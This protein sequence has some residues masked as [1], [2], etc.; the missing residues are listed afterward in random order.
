MTTQFKAG[1]RVTV[2]AH[3]GGLFHSRNEGK[4]G[5]VTKVVDDL[6]Y[7]E[8]D[9]EEDYGYTSNVKLA[10]PRYCYSPRRLD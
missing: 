8:F 6:L 5:T 10:A 3:R 2:T 7:V 1:N 9:G 4:T